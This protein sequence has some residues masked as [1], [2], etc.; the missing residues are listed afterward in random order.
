M[1]RIRTGR[2]NGR[3]PLAREERQHVVD[4]HLHIPLELIEK[5]D[6]L[7]EGNQTR[8]DVIISA[9]RDLVERKGVQMSQAQK[10]SSTLE[11]YLESEDFKQGVI[12]ST[13]ASWGGSCYKVEI[14]PDGTWRN[15][16][17]NQIGN[18]YESEGVIIALPA[19]DCS[20]MEEF[21][22]GGRTEDEYFSLSFDNARDELVSELRDALKA[23]A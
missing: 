13:R 6:Q 9:I 10:L 12:D 18:R 4:M 7:R 23:R 19:L 2:P 21:T 1:A 5:I 20:D 16:W 14:M 3:P 8:K 15:L 22:E 11:Q 17:A